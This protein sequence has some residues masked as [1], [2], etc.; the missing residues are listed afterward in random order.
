MDEPGRSFAASDR[1]LERA[2][3]DL[4][5][6]IAYPAAPDIASRVQ[7]RLATEPEPHRHVSS[8][9]T[10]DLGR[11]SRTQESATRF[12]ASSE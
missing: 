6:V 7:V 5:R 2:L 1:E 11:R 8:R 9:G 10:R 3:I 4:G 12:L